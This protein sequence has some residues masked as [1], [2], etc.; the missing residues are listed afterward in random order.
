MSF[1][2]NVTGLMRLGPGSG[3][4]VFRESLKQINGIV[5]PDC[6]I[7]HSLEMCSTEMPCINEQHTLLE[8]VAFIVYLCIIL[9]LIKETWAQF[10][11]FE[12]F[13]Y[14]V[15]QYGPMY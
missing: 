6:R 8:I 7:N 14:K 5:L 13:T 11:V 15:L 10:L 4:V 9:S 1:C 3:W 2:W 12:Y